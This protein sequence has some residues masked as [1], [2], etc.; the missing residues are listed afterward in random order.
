VFV[1]N[2]LERKREM[3]R[4]CARLLPKCLS[5]LERAEVCSSVLTGTELL[6]QDL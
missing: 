6:R 1:C 4:N 3:G 5:A 2:A